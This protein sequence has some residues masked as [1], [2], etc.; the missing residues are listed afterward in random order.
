MVVALSLVTD[1]ASQT[2]RGIG[3]TTAQIDGFLGN[4]SASIS[5]PG[6]LGNAIAQI[7]GILG[8]IPASIPRLGC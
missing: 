4:I 8:N 3:N 6:R 2:K 7:G 1:E 5:R